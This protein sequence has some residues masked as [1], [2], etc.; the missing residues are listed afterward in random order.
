[1]TPTETALA[2]AR[3]VVKASSGTRLPMD[4]GRDTPAEELW[5]ALLNLAA[6]M[7]QVCGPRLGVV[8]DVAELRRER[9]AAQQALE[10]AEAEAEKWRSEARRT[11]AAEGRVGMLEVVVRDTLLALGGCITE[12]PCGDCP[13]CRAVT[14]LA[15]EIK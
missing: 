6:A 8:E 2:A 3:A 11:L 15:K 12:P 1:M 14:V 4:T 9:D 13:Y 10:H 5:G 7:G